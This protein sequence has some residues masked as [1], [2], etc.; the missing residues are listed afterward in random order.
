MK[1]KILEMVKNGMTYKQIQKELNC[2]ISTISYHC[3]NS[4]IKSLHIQEKLDDELIDKIRETYKILKSSDKVS[5][6]FNIS[7]T[8]VLKYIDVEKRIKLTNDEFKKSRV[9]RVIYWRVKAKSILVEYLGGKC[10]MCGYNKCI[11]A[12]DFHHIDPNMKDFTIS[13]KSFSIDR[14][15]KET[16]KCILVCSNC[17]REIHFNIKNNKYL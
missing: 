7:K 4:K 8:S 14:L 15:K 1:D 12:L 10:S 5:K 9:K 16:D 3:K 13:G 17:H 2:A 11:D 6:I